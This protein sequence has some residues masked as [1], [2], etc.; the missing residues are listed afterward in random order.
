M[1]T[2]LFGVLR[3]QVRFSDAFNSYQ[4]ALPFVVEDIAATSDDLVSDQLKST[5]AVIKEDEEDYFDSDGDGD[6]DFDDISF[7][8]NDHPALFFTE[9]DLLTHQNTI[10]NSYLKSKNLSRKEHQRLRQEQRGKNR[11]S[12]SQLLKGT[13]TTGIVERMSQPSRTI[14]EAID[15]LT[16]Y[17]SGG[18][19]KPPER[20]RHS[21]N[22]RRRIANDSASTS[23][24]QQQQPSQ[25][26]SNERTGQQRVV[27]E[28]PIEVIG[29]VM[30]KPINLPH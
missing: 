3:A 20:R 16:L 14:A 10:H 9:E 21:E 2:A 4:E 19:P 23:Q 27:E 26:E 12:L 29:H 11:A 18:K 30:P 6:E 7:D 15:S 13:G 25:P 5:D 8:E 24:R 1:M 17:K 22:E 28:P